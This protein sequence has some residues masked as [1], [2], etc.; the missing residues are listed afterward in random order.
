[1]LNYFKTK[2]HLL[3]DNV[4]RFAPLTD[5]NTGKRQV[6]GL[7]IIFIAVT[8]RSSLVTT[9]RFS[10]SR[11]GL[12]CGPNHRIA[13]PAS[14]SWI[15]LPRKRSRGFVGV[16]AAALQKEAKCEAEGKRTKP[17][18]PKGPNIQQ[19]ASGNGHTIPM[20]YLKF[21]SAMSSAVSRVLKAVCLIVLIRQQ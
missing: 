21:E 13:W 18:R 6:F 17:P 8:G 19:C 14:K 9:A 10:V 7:L 20:F 15:R 11:A 16:S 5:P 3:V 2:A 4:H 12:H 1:M